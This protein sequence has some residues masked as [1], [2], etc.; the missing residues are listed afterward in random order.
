[1]NNI[2]VVLSQ[3]ILAQVAPYVLHIGEIVIYTYRKRSFGCQAPLA[4][5]VNGSTAKA[6]APQWR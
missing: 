3:S 5:A 6:M 2:V 4:V 1:M